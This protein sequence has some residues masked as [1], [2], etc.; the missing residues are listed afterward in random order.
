[1]RG[2]LAAV[3]GTAMVIGL[4][5]CS[6]SAEPP[7]KSESSSS[8][9]SSSESS[10]SSASSSASESASAGSGDFK[11]TIDGADKPINGSVSCVS[12][13]G[14]VNITI[15]EGT[16]AILASVSE[17]DNPTVSSV[18]LGNVDGAVL[19][20]GMGAGNAEAK[21][22]GN[23]YTITGEATGID[24]SKPLSPVTKPFEIVATCP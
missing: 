4:V 13:G 23:T 11:V 16:T 5:G 8:E 10:S 19:A 20:V 3:G 9:S 2:L 6:S 15:G 14:N 18:G 22:D 24:I 7:A 17:G 12:L 21:K 1:M